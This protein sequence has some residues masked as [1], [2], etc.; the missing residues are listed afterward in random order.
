MEAVGPYLSWIVMCIVSFLWVGF[1][2]GLI[3]ILIDCITVP[4]L[5]IFASVTRLRV[6][7]KYFANKMA[8][9]HF[10]LISTGSIMLLLLENSF[11]KSGWFVGFLIVGVLSNCVALAQAEGKRQPY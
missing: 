7:Y 5:V 11:F 6:S 9:Y 10:I 1:C 2:A 3:A 8:L 4:I